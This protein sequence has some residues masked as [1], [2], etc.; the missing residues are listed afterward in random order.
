[1]GIRK[2]IPKKSINTRIKDHNA[3]L[4]TSAVNRFFARHPKNYP[5]IVKTY[6]WRYEETSVQFLDGEGNQL[7]VTKEYARKHFS[8][9]RLYKEIK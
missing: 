2:G 7:V 1:M 4:V 5:Y 3:N 6:E 9:P 8:P